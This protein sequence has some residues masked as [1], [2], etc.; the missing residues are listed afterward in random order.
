MDNQKQ[1]RAAYGAEATDQQAEGRM[2]ASRDDPRGSGGAAPATGADDMLKLMEKNPR[3]CGLGGWMKCLRKPALSLQYTVDKRHVPDM[4]SDPT[5]QAE[6]PG[7]NSD[8]MTVKG[9][10]TIRYFD[11]AAGMLLLMVAGCFIKGCC[12]LKRMM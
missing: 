10:F 5:G 2:S 9:G 4:D 3:V 6:V 8:T 7:A 11:L 12:C 1:D